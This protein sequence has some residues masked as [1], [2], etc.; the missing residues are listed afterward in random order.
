MGSIYN[1]QFLGNI[2]VVGRTNCGK[3]TFIEKLGLNN[4]FGNIVKTE[5]VSGT[6]IDKKI[7]AEIQSYFKNET[8]VHIAQDQDKLDSLIDTLKQRSHENYDDV[9][10]NNV[11]SSFGENKKMDRPIIMDDVSGIADVSRNFSNFLTVSRKFG[12]NCVYVFQVIVPSSQVWQKIF[13]QTNIFNIFSASVPFNTASKI[14]QSNCILQNKKYVPAHSLWLNRVF[15]DLANSHEKHCLIIDCGY[16]NKNSPGH[17]Q[18]W[19]DNPDRQVCYFNKPGDNVFY[20]TFI[21]ERIKEGE[22]SEG[23]YFKIEKVGGNNDKENFD[24]KIILEDGA[25]N[26]KSDGI[27]AVSKPEQDG[28]GAGTVRPGNKRF[29][30]SFEN[31]YRR[32]RKSAKPKFLS[33]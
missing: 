20:N 24:A 25:S 10:K 2:L 22:Y 29:G 21:S 18:S 32:K 27:Y 15:S 4:F 6:A 7:E 33:G 12:Y 8:E 5:W 17:Y 14:I 26:A 30:D 9:N 31:L 19:A 1:G 3:T 28:A 11:H 23:I 16:L 13:S